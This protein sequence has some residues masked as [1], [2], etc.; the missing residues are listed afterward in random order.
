M[1][2][3]LVSV[4]SAE[5]ARRALAGGASIIDV[6]E[7]SNGSLGRASFESWREVEHVMPADFR[8]SVALGELPEWLGGDRPEAPPGAFEGIRYRKVGLAGVGPNWLEEWNEL[9]RRLDAP[10][11]GWFAVVY[12]DWEAAGAPAPRS[13]LNAGIDYEGVLFD[14]WD[15]SKTAEWTPDLIGI[16]SD[17]REDDRM[18]AVAGGLTRDNLDAIA[19]IR[20]D[21]VAVRGAACENGDR[22]RDVDQHRVEELAEIVRG[23]PGRRRGQ[24]TSN[25][26][27]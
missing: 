12:L 2:E 11:A 25:R 6:K 18:L 7:P 24:P 10:G 26:T 23:L 13:I 14:T 19:D 21:V 27:P 5:E 8:M 9:V 3:L 22:L 4:R 1:A 16:A 17:F 20:P 15:K